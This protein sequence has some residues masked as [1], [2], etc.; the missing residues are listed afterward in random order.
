MIRCTRCHRKLT[1]PPRNGM[2]PSCAR[3]MFGPEPKAAKA[4]KAR[5]RA[6]TR[7]DS[8]QAELDL[9]ERETVHGVRTAV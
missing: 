9:R 2:G 5:Q 1:N 3:A 4:P 8:R 7:I 6:A